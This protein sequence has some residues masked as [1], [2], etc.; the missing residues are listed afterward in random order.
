MDLG[1]LE[2]DDVTPAFAMLREVDSI[3]FD[4]RGYPN[5]TAWA[6]TPWL[7]AEPA[8]AAQIWRPTHLLGWSGK[9]QFEQ[10][11]PAGAEWQ[12][13]GRIVVLIN[14]KAISQ[15]E[16]TCL[17]IES[18]HD[19]VTFVGSPTNGANGD[20]TAIGMPGGMTVYFTGHDIRHADGRQLQRLGIQPDIEVTPTVA[21]IREGRDEV[22]EAAIRFLQLEKG[23]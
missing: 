14:E 21:G 7:A 8:T 22:L 13:Q 15:S 16:H 11:F 19:D 23:S 1:R 6:I 12:W 10:T 18:A 2:R 17:F 3:I 9:F 20:I 5:G 4:I